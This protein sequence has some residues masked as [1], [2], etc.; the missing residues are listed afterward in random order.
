MFPFPGGLGGGFLGG[1]R[2]GQGDGGLGE[3]RGGGEERYVRGFLF[4]RCRLQVIN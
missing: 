3:G 1:I 4:I 2:V